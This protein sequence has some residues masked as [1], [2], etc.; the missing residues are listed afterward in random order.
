M[1][2]GMTFLAGAAGHVFVSYVRED[3]ERADR[4]QR[5]LQAAGNWPPRGS[6]HPCATSGL[7]GL[8]VITR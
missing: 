8:T 7:P 1:L 4:P 2:M 3:A 6:S 5:M